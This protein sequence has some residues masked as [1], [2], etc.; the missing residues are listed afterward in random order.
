V[1]VGGRTK[2]VIDTIGQRGGQALA[3]LVL[4]AVLA[5]S[6]WDGPVAILAVLAALAWLVVAFDLR[7]HY[8]NVFRDTLR[9]DMTETRIAFPA[10]DVASL[11]TLLRTLNDADE[12]RVLAALELLGDQGKTPVVPALILYHPSPRVVLLALDLF[13]RDGRTD[14]LAIAERLVADGNPQV[15]SAALRAHSRLRPTEALLRRGLE[16]PAPE[17]KVTAAIGLAASGWLPAE[18]ARELLHPVLENGPAAAQLA[19]LSAL[20]THPQAGLEDLAIELLHAPA[21][22]VRIGAVRAMGDVRTPA[23][24]PHLMSAL[25]HRELR[26]FARAALVAH[27]PAALSSVDQAL[28]DPELP[29]PV[30]RQLARVVAAFGTVEAAGVLARHLLRGSGGLVQFQVLR[31]LGRLRTAH[32]ELP[33]DEAVLARAIEQTQAHA[34][35]FSRWR[36]ALAQGAVRDGARRTDLHTVLVTLLR[37][38]QQHAVERLFRLLNLLARDEEYEQIHRGL[39]SA[40]PTSRAGGREL[41]EHVAPE[42]LRDPILALLD[43]L[44]EAQPVHAAGRHDHG[45]VTTLRELISGPVESLSALAAAH[46]AELGLDEL[47]AAIGA[48]STASTVLGE[49]LRRATDTLTAPGARRG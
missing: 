31:A 43:D 24:I 27:G 23:G 8:L 9:E 39:R 17:V 12:R 36:Q 44:D 32:P 20:R 37:Q 22:P 48:R 3:S 49:V 10:L 29:D 4:L 1:G 28:G 25:S 19:L 7:P 42:R 21:A 2:A 15:A 34:F 41:L 46:A 35:A 40:R 14:F 5:V 26:D 33:V 45:Y 16:H 18:R 6:S 47:A 13:E 38:K 30:R 11:E